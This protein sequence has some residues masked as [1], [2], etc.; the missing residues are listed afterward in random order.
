MLNLKAI[1]QQS[2]EIFSK[3]KDIVLEHKL[4]AMLI[5][6]L[7]CLLLLLILL[8]SYPKK[9][10]NEVSQDIYPFELIHPYELP[11]EKED[12]SY[13]FSRDTKKSWSKDEALQ[14]FSE[15]DGLLLNELENKNTKKVTDILEAAP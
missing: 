8:I 13:Y 5:L 3:I 4:Q 7:L 15:P 2:K 14:W 6:L 10:K 9:N 12:E 1:I 11:I